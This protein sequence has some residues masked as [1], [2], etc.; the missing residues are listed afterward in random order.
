MNDQ[1]FAGFGE[2]IVPTEAGLAA[3]RTNSYLPAARQRGGVSLDNPFHRT[4]PSAPRVAS[5]NFLGWGL[6][7]PGRGGLPPPRCHSPSKPTA[8]T[9]LDRWA[10]PGGGGSCR[11]MPLGT[12]LV[13]TLSDTAAA[14]NREDLSG[15]EAAKILV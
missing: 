4:T 5:R 1:W 7:P 8:P 12:A 3:T 10:W 11:E 13:L 6:P 15:P 2:Q 9:N 14:G